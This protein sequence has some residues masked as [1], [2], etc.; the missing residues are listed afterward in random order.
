[1]EYAASIWQTGNCVQL[2]KVQRQ[3]LAVCMGV[4]ETAALDAL[5]VEAGIS[6][7]NLRQEAFIGKGTGKNFS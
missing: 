1:M 4:A 7:L 2:E 6:P 5:E 3:C